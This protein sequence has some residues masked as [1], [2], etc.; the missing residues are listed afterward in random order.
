[1][2]YRDNSLFKDIIELKIK[3]IGRNKGLTNIKQGN[4]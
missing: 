4:K 1:M 3:N 2:N